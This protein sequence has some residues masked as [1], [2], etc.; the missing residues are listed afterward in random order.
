METIQVYQE[1]LDNATSKEE[2][3][4]IQLTLDTMTNQLQEIENPDSKTST[5]QRSTK[6]D[7]QK[8]KKKEV[9]Q[10]TKE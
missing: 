5:P 9:R 6:P 2:K 7:F 1:M 8:V 3:E 10:L 4:I